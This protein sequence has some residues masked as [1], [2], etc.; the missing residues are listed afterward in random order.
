MQW[1]VTGHL[2][3]FKLLCKARATNCLVSVSVAAIFQTQI[4]L[5]LVAMIVV[6]TASLTILM[7]QTQEKFTKQVFQTRMC[8][9]A[10]VYNLQISFIS[11]CT[12]A[13]DIYFLHQRPELKFSLIVKASPSIKSVYQTLSFQLKG[14][15]GRHPTRV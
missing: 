10:D 8:N 5:M 1:P 2:L 12:M 14:F 3:L 11:C 7:T 9:S 6:I 4:A 13:L 15:A